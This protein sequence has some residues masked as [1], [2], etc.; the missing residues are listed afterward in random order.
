MNEWGSRPWFWVCLMWMHK[1]TWVHSLQKQWQ[2][3]TL[4]IRGDKWNIHAWTG[5]CKYGQLG[6]IAPI[7]CN[8]PAS[9]QIPPSTRNWLLLPLHTRW[10]PDQASLFWVNFSSSRSV[11]TEQT[12]FW[13]KILSEI[14]L[15]SGL[16][17]PWVYLTELFWGLCS[18][19]SE[20]RWR[21]YRTEIV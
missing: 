11:V 20:C 8:S 17:N 15:S 6:G 5:K 19:M 4:W 18:V 9:S 10:L 13:I 21:N 12:C 7:A 2:Q 3:K 14:T 1:A 16:P